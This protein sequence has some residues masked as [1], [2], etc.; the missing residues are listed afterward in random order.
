MTLSKP[1]RDLLA[2]QQRVIEA[3]SRYSTWR[4]ARA[5]HAVQGAH[6]EAQEQSA[7]AELAALASTGDDEVLR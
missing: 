7:F 6:L 4:R 2:H 3:H 1:N 5:A